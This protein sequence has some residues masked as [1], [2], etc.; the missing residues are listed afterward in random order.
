MGP[1]Q[2]RGGRRPQQLDLGIFYGPADDPDDAIMDIR[3]DENFFEDDGFEEA[4]GY[5]HFCEHFRIN[6]G[7][8]CNECSKC[9]LYQAED[10]EAVARRAG[11]EAEREWRLRHEGSSTNNE[12]PRLSLRNINED[13]SAATQSSLYARRASTTLWNMHFPDPNRSWCYWLRDV[14]ADGRWRLEGQ[15]LMDWLVDK[16]IVIEDF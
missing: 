3:G 4:E 13:L 1:P 9:D 12:T 11:E 6:P 7:S 16:A 5:K 15:M 10:E 8:R 2:R 14:W